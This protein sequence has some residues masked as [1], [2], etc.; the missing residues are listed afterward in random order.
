MRES[1]KK[2]QQQQQQR[3]ARSARAASSAHDD[4]KA[5]LAQ[6]AAKRQQSAARSKQAERARE[7]ELRREEEEDDE[8]ASDGG[9]EEGE[10]ADGSS[11]RAPPRASSSADAA[12]AAPRESAAPVAALE[13]IRLSRRK[14]EQWLNEPFF[15][16]CLPGCFV[17]V[18]IGKSQE[19]QPMY[20]VAEVVGV[21]DG[22]R[23][24]TVEK[25]VTTKR[26]ELQIGASRRHFQVNYLSNADFEMTEL[27]KY[28]RIMRQAN[29]RLK[30]TTEINAKVKELVACKTHD[31]QDHEVDAMVKHRQQTMKMKGNLAH[32]KM[33]LRGEIDAMMQARDE[34][35]A[36]VEAHRKELAEYAREPA[37]KEEPRAPGPEPHT[38]EDVKKKEEELRQLDQKQDLEKKI[39][40]QREGSSFRITDINIR[41]RKFQ[42]EIEDKVGL[43]HLKSE[44][45][46]TSGRV[47]ASDPFK[48]LPMRPVI[49]WD[50]GKKK[51]AEDEAA[52]PAAPPARP[53]STSAA[54]GTG[55]VVDVDSPGVA[56]L[57]ETPRG[58][59]EDA[60][61][62]SSQEAGGLPRLA[63]KRA[64]AHEIDI[65]IDIPD[66]EDGEAERKAG[67]VPRSWLAGARPSA[68]GGG[69]GGGGQRLSLRDYKARLESQAE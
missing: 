17:R 56:A 37:G 26:L 12:S 39:E 32:R 69:M 31:Y 46:L 44:V 10:M 60:G 18:G 24:Y 23:Q 27:E 4:K 15:E 6:L 9:S 62:S 36:Q 42:R 54:A 28:T 63:G 8:R 13:R 1:R 40:Q 59:D 16:T 66:K 25:N 35:Q 65:E 45:E 5:K 30:T 38:A 48:R 50:I 29:L 19:G 53:G 7:E 43:E 41:N 14:I 20:R 64:Q 22:F 47:T 11:S 67:P 52:A 34:H 33:Q 58:A 49:Y 2:Q 68:G 3:T 57:A 21:K 61:A 51:G 55:A